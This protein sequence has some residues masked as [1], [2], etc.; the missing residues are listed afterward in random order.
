MDAMGYVKGGD[1]RGHLVAQSL[2]GDQS[3]LNIVPMAINVNRYR[4]VGDRGDIDPNRVINPNAL[5]VKNNMKDMNY[6]LSVWRDNEKYTADL[7]AHT[8]NRVRYTVIVQ[9]DNDV[10]AEL[11]NNRNRFRPQQLRPT[12]FIQII[13]EID[14]NG[15]VIGTPIMNRY[16]N[17]QEFQCSEEGIDELRRR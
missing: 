4:V 13:E 11:E 7:V 2:G 15:A 17:S 5:T 8:R 10:I 3:V 12:H 1:D 9:Y 6:P 16:V 14:G